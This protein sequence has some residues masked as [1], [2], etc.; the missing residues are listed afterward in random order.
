MREN[1]RTSEP[2]GKGPQVTTCEKE[3]E[4]RKEAGNQSGYTIVSAERSEST[5]DSE[6]VC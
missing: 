1:R 2:G 3:Q 6:A 4:E 5:F